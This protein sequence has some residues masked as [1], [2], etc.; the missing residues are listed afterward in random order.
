MR[1]GREGKGNRPVR[2]GSAR[3]PRRGAKESRPLYRFKSEGSA[4]I[5]AGYQTT[6]IGSTLGLEVMIRQVLLKPIFR[7]IYCEV[8]RFFARKSYAKME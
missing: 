6:S 8:Q 1:I 7:K 2:T 3:P 4:K 5:L